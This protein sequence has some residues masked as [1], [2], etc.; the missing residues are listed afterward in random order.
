MFPTQY[1]LPSMFPRQYNLSVSA[2]SPV[3]PQGSSLPVAS[4][5][6]H[7]LGTVVRNT[8]G[9]GMFFAFLGKHGKY[10]AANEQYTHAG[11]L[12]QWCAVTKLGRYWRHYENALARGN[13]SLESTPA[14]VL[15][16]FSTSLPVQLE[17]SSGS[18]GYSAPLTGPSPNSAFVH[19]VP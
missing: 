14:V 16:D 9:V 4:A 10:L 18:L 3:V 11:N 13:L 1:L 15:Y 12:A 19:N 7:A 8:S 5:A 17:L 2:V 6:D